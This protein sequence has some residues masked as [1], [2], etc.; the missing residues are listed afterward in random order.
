MKKLRVMLSL[1]LPLVFPIF[2]AACSSGGGTSSGSLTI[3]GLQTS[4]SASAGD[5]QILTYNVTIKNQ[6][7]NNVFVET[8]EP[9]LSAS[10]E[11][12]VLVDNLI[13]QVDR[14]VIS[15][16]TFEVSGSFPFDAK[17]LTKQDIEKL[18]P[19]FTGIRVVSDEML[20]V[21]GK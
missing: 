9:V 1:V 15:G 10:F 6:S 14:N 12:R 21:P 3:I 16:G 8:A 17:G 18:Q 4:I 7:G 11:P 19:Y 2:S 5:T 20:K 13:K